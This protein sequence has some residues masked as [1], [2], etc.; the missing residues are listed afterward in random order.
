MVTCRQHAAIIFAQN[1]IF[2]E[3]VCVVFRVIQKSCAY[4]TKVQNKNIHDFIF[5]FR[6]KRRNLKKER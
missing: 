5:D 6:F 2:A 4:L 3:V 1:Y